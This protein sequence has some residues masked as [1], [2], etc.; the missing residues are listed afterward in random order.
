MKTWIVA[1]AL[2]AVS[3]GAHNALAAE[4]DPR[5]AVDLSGDT[6]PWALRGLNQSI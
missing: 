4:Q 6:P 3:E 1:L 5:E 2:L